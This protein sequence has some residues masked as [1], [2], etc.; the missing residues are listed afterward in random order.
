MGNC[1]CI[2]PHEVTEGLI[3]SPE[4]NKRTG[5]YLFSIGKYKEA[6]A[7]YRAC[8]NRNPNNSVYY[9]N[10]A[11]CCYKLLMYKEAFENAICGF[12]I[13]RNNA[14][15][16]ALCVK[17]KVALCLGGSVR[18]WQEALGFCSQ[19][20][21]YKG[22]KGREGDYQYGKRMLPKVENLG[23]RVKL[24]ERKNRVLAYY[25]VNTQSMFPAIL[26]I[27]NRES[28]SLN[29]IICPLTLVFYS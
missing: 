22:V 4:E 18:E 7:Q 17:A 1:L 15:A 12:K 21:L 24:T 25:T 20:E 27:I 19:F 8:I 23:F 29:S 6:S 14:K 26:R 2:K 11:I 5:N 28:P 3:A 13:D 9:S 16:L 10:N